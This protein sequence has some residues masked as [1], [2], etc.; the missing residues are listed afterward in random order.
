MDAYLD[1]LTRKPS[2]PSSPPREQLGLWSE[3]GTSEHETEIQLLIPI[4]QRLA[5]E[6]GVSGVTVADVREEAARKGLIPPLGKGR[7]LS[8]LGAL[9]K[10]AG[11]VATDRTRRSHIEGSN[12]NRQTVHIAPEYREKVA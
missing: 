1:S 11:L 3:S 2:R 12:G 7:S 6:A 8:Y 4:A 9:M 5:R 10:R